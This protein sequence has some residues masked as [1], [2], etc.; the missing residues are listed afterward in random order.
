MDILSRTD[1]AFTLT[2]V[3][4]SEPDGPYLRRSSCFL[5]IRSS[6]VCPVKYFRGLEI[7]Q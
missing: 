2:I 3:T 4:R 7:L 1:N 6:A 5:P